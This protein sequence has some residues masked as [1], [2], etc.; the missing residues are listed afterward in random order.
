MNKILAFEYLLYSLLL[1]NKE[2]S[3]NTD[4]NVLVKSFSRLK[5]L[6]L[7]F[8]TSA[9]NSSPEN[10]GLL[11]TFD[12]FYAMQHGPVESDIYNAMINKETKIF[13]FSKRETAINLRMINRF[14]SLD[15]ELKVEIDNSINELKRA[16]SSIITYSP[17]D[18]VDITHKWESWKVA[19]EIAHLFNRGSELMNVNDIKSDVK[20]FS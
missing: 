15:E 18:L 10:D 8:L 6:K 5:A 9:I 4:L 19:I 7:L 17:F 14:K 3:G 11:K 16:N 2:A 1:W 20:Y 13:D 12:T